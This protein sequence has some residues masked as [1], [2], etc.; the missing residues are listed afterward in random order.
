MIITKK[1]WTIS[2]DSIKEEIESLRDGNYELIFKRISDLRTAR[3]NRYLHKV[4]TILGNHFGYDME[5]MKDL[6]KNQFLK[7]RRYLKV[8]GKRK[9]IVRIKGTSQLSKE[10]F[11]RFFDKIKAFADQ[12]GVH[13]PDPSLYQIEVFYNL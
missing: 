7:E 9:Q 1:D 3:Q 5:E 4:F 10:E 11:S 12:S 13:L 6:I 8:N 2:G